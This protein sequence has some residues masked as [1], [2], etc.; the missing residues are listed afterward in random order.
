MESLPDGGSIP[1]L[2]GSGVMVLVRRSPMDDVPDRRRLS[3]ALRIQSEREPF[4]PFEQG[5]FRAVVLL[6]SP[7]D[8]P[9]NPPSRR[10]QVPAVVVAHHV[11]QHLVSHSTRPVSHAVR[12]HAVRQPARRDDFQTVAEDRQPDGVTGELAIAVNQGVDDT[13]AKRIA[14]IGRTLQPPFAPCFH[15]GMGVALHEFQGLLDEA[16]VH[17]IA[18]FARQ[19]G[20]GAAKLRALPG[21]RVPVRSGIG[22]RVYPRM[23]QEPVRHRAEQQHAGDSDAFPGH[24]PGVGE[25]RLPRLPVFVGGHILPADIDEI[26]SQPP[27]VQAQERGARYGTQFVTYG[28]SLREQT[29]EFL[30]ACFPTPRADADRISVGVVVPERMHAVSAGHADDGNIAFFPDIAKHLEER[31]DG[32]PDPVAAYV[33]HPSFEVVPHQA[34]D[35]SVVFGA[36]Q[37]HAAL[38]VR[39]S[40]QLLREGPGVQIVPPECHPGISAI[41]DDFQQ[42]GACRHASEPVTGA[43]RPERFP[44]NP[45]LGNLLLSGEPCQNPVDIR[46]KADCGITTTGFSPELYTIRRYSASGASRQFSRPV[47]ADKW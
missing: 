44:H 12:R 9:G 4:V 6:H 7:D 26:V 16:V 8:Y 37:D 34:R 43:A 20:H 15:D 31:N 11:L 19:G 29:H 2:R 38:E 1:W 32:R 22:D 24:D 30:P 47:T 23:R 36:E 45:D 27:P 42:F 13:F 18:V 14:G 40:G 46:R 41:R 39:E 10:F 28:A 25:K 5:G 33:H 21:V 3:L 35:G 17:D